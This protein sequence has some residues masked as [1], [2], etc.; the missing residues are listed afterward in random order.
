MIWMPEDVLLSAD[1]DGPRYVRH[2]AGVTV[3]HKGRVCMLRIEGEKNVYS[4]WPV[5]NELGARNTLALGI[6][7]Y[8]QFQRLS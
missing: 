7:L 5:C 2:R 8:D 3:G 4:W 1:P 6:Q